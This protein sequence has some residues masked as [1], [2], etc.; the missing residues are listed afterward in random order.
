MKTPAILLAALSLF[1]PLLLTPPQTV[2]QSAPGAFSQAPHSNN[3]S[4][5]KSAR[6][7]EALKTG[8]LDAFADLTGQDAVFVDAHGSATKAE[9]M[10]NQ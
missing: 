9:V 2:A 7:S 6:V 3:R 4:S 1:I 5:R 10:K 8:N